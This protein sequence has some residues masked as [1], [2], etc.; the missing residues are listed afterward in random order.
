M[1][2]LLRRCAVDSCDEFDF[3]QMAR[4]SRVC[5]GWHAEIMPCL[6]S[7]TKLLTT[8]L[9]RLSTALYVCLHALKLLHA[10]MNVC[11]QST[12]RVWKGGWQ[13]IQC[14]SHSARGVNC[15]NRRELRS[16]AL[17]PTFPS[18]WLRAISVCCIEAGFN[19]TCDARDRLEDDP[20]SDAWYKRH[21][22][23]SAHANR[24][25]LAQRPAAR[26][27]PATNGRRLVSTRHASTLVHVRRAATVVHCACRGC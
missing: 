5:R 6:R 18:K 27:A 26:R 23:S 2:A 7:L 20:G 22:H 13:G 17:C 21:I 9:Q 14:L 16:R 15:P 24:A 4:I 19:L 1:D 10:R 12:K 8:E 11:M 25:I 3:R